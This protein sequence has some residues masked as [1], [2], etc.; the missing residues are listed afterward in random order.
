MA[1]YKNDAWLINYFW[2]WGLVNEPY[3]LNREAS[4]ELP[5]IR[6][7][8]DLSSPLWNAGSY[9]CEF[10]Q[11]MLA[12]VGYEA[13]KL[14]RLPHLPD[15]DW[16]SLHRCCVTWRESTSKIGIGC[17]VTWDKGT[18]TLHS[19]DMNAVLHPW[20]TQKGWSVAYGS[21]KTPATLSNAHILP[22]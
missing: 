16:I 2:M 8:L 5:W 6:S 20:A 3:I 1:Y 14:R 12:T 21:L 7:F 19:E 4:S 13:F 18:L 22:F 9:A 10:L 15:V 17:S 11:K